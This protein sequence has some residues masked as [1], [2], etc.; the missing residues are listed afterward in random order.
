MIFSL[1]VTLI[2]MAYARN[3]EKLRKEIAEHAE[4]VEQ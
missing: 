2:Q 4:D 3:L 1:V